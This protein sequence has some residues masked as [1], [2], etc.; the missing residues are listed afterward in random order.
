MSIDNRIMDIFEEHRIR[1]VISVPCKNLSGLLKGLEKHEKI[2]LIYPARE[3]EGLGI[4]A[5]CYLGGARSVMLIQNSGLGNMVNA[6]KS[7]MQYYDMPFF[8]IVSQRGGKEEK[9]EAQK[10]MGEATK[11]LLDVLKVK[12]LVFNDPGHVSGL[13]NLIKKC[14]ENNESTVVL[15]EP[16]FFRGECGR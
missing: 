7:L 14:F 13:G 3:E 1:F 4:S 2:R 12:S 5:G 9:I 16:S 6:I 11:E 10:P 15:A 8:I